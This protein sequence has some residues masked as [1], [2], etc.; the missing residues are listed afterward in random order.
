MR[1]L[2][3]LI[4][5][6][7]VGCSRVSVLEIDFIAHDSVLA[8]GKRFL[9]RTKEDGYRLRRHFPEAEEIRFRN[10]DNCRMSD[11]W[12]LIDVR[13]PTGESFEEV[14]NPVGSYIFVMRDGRLRSIKWFGRFSD[15]VWGEKID[16]GKCLEVD[17]VEFAG[18]FPAVDDGSF[19]HLKFRVKD[20]AGAIL[21][22]IIEQYDAAGGGEKDIYLL[23]Y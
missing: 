23:P 19:L 22:D 16:A 4:V 1:L 6:A 8:N 21:M 18:T 11:I 13:H 17:C 15:P 9:L 2:F 10:V 14:L 12:N 3:L 5:M 7:L 20:T